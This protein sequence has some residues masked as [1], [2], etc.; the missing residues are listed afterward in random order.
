MSYATPAELIERLGA[1]EAAKL[2]DRRTPFTV[3]GAGLARA[4]RGESIADLSANEQAATAEAVAN[5]TQALRDASDTID[6]YIAARAQLPLASTPR[7]LTR[8]AVELGRVYLRRGEAT[9]E[10]RRLG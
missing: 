1:D 2:A 5:I 7:V 6:G 3:R 10:M 9:E 4:A 8:L